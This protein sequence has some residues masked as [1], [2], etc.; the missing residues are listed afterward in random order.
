MDAGR[1]ARPTVEGERVPAD[2]VNPWV[3]DSVA[4][5]LAGAGDVVEVHPDD[6]KSGSSF[7]R[8]TIDGER[9]FVKS[10]S[11]A[12]DWITRV[13]GDT[14]GWP[15]EVWKAGI[16]HR[17][18]P[19]IDHTVVGMA[20][21]GDG[22]DT[23]LTFLMHDI[24][25]YLVPE[26]DERVTS[27]THAG[28]LDGLAALS[29]ATWGWADTIGL[30]TLE[31]RFRFFAPATIAPELARPWPEGPPGPIA[32][33]DEGWRRLAERAPELHRVTTALHD[34]P[35]P[36]AAALRETP[37]CFLH[38][39]WKMGNLGRHPDG[40][41]ILLDWAYPGEGPPCWDLAWYL[42]LN[43]ARLPQPKEG[44]VA[45]FREALERR[46]I[47]TSGWFADQMALCLLANMVTFGWEKAL[48]ADDELRWWAE[49]AEAGGRRL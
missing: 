7:R 44:A 22:E 6:G 40:R 4:D 45:S 48:G 42:S 41:T 15:L 14:R 28:F 12:T 43:A 21:E 5:L 35:G 24:E 9:Y 10:V 34:E 47:D 2:A 29:A 17:V 3:A 16:M 11:R 26:G 25:P 33:A 1:D 49:V 8:V 18:P 13:I 39:D 30:C 27:E 31:Q 37:A 32:A 36:L 23:V 20:V 46:G 38:G 19:E